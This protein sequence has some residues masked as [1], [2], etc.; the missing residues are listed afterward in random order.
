M[1][2][3]SLAQVLVVD[4]VVESDIADVISAHFD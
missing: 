1:D 3:V 4:A 2:R